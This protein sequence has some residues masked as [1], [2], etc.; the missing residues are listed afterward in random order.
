MWNVYQEHAHSVKFC[1]CMYYIHNLLSFHATVHP[2][3]LGECIPSLLTVIKRAG[4]MLTPIFMH[5]LHFHLTIGLL[6]AGNLEEL[7]YFGHCCSI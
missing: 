5:Q 1:M 7:Q 3:L 2:N 6:A 4:D